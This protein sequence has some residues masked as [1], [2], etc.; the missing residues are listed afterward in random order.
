M[1]TP[2]QQ[3][4]VTDL[5]AGARTPV[6]RFRERVRLRVGI[7]DLLV[8]RVG[9]ERFALPVESVNELVESPSARPVPGAPDALLGV[10]PFD[11]RLLSLYSPEPFLGARLVGDPV[12]LIMRSGSR[13]L[14]LAVDDAEDVIRVDLQEVRPAPRSLRD[15]D[16]VLGVLWR[17]PELIALLDARALAAS[18]AAL[19][20][21]VA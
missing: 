15:D 17:A 14:A 12:G 3:P 7:Q 20:A 10:F 19:G 8:V 1:Q 21:A 16:L 2:P 4:L 5:P 6:L 18:C 9:E 11:D 13:T